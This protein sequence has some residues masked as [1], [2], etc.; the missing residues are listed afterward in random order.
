M[1]EEPSSNPWEID[2]DH[3]VGILRKSKES[4][5]TSGNNAPAAFLA[6]ATVGIIATLI[7]GTN[8]AIATWQN[9]L[10][11]SAHIQLTELNEQVTA[12]CDGN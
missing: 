4:S 1:S 9:H 11:S 5:T 8:Q 7:Y 6:L 3:A 2:P 10:A 12:F